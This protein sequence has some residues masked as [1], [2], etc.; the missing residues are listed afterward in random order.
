VNSGLKGA[1]SGE[2]AFLEGRPLAPFLNES[3]RLALKPA[4]VGACIGLLGSYP[5]NRR[6]SAGRAFAYGLL[7]GAL[8]FGVGIAWG[9]RR[10]AASVAAGA[11]KS[12][13]RVRDE[14]WLEQNPIDYA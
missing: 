5:G 9:S 4:A 11:A 1:R 7:G 8:G 2:E 3:V 10:L 13:G 14:H 6:M 12:M